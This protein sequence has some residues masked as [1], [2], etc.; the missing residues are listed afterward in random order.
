MAARPRTKRGR[1][2]Q[3]PAVQAPAHD[4]GAE[5]IHEELV[6]EKPVAWLAA[7]LTLLAVVV[8]VWFTPR[9]TG[10]T[11]MMLAGGQDFFE[12]KLGEVDDWAFTTPDR[13]WINQSW[14][15]G[16]LFYAIRGRSRLQLM[17]ARE[18]GHLI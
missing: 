17:N 3:Q 12:G 13:I 11:F 6:R 2:Q 15:T 7:S 14:G 10:D 18:M 8:H 4:A 1:T 5:T 9:M 16:V